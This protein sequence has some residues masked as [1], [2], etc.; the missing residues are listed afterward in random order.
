MHQIKDY[1]KLMGEINL[2]QTWVGLQ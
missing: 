2:W 1:V